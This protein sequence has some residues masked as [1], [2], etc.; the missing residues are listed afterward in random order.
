ME[1]FQHVLFKLIYIKFQMNI[2]ITGASGDI[3]RAISKRLSGAGHKTVGHYWN[4]PVPGAPSHSP[5]AKADLA[6]PYQ[7]I[8]LFKTAL[9]Q[10]GSIDVLINNAGFCA[11]C[12]PDSVFDAWLE[13]WD[14][15]MAINLRASAI[16]SK[17]AIVY[18]SERHFIDRSKIGRIIFVASRAAFRGD[19]KELF[20]YAASKAGI[21]ALSHS[22]A[23]AY[24]KENIFS[25]VV[26]PGPVKGSFVGKDV[27]IYGPEAVF[28]DI[29]TKRKTEPD[30]IAKVVT[31]L[32]GG[33]FDQATGCV[34][35]VNGASYVH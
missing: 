27:S 19:T 25:F 22:I 18:F 24:G 20:A 10:L 3:G 5:S 17:K 13:N 26:A 33:D 2:L 30:D 4:H 31:A 6:D 21:V 29:N 11:H 12:E 7:A 14:K 28:G 32:V 9:G 34:I 23:R 35:D 16:L 1:F 8:E 15:T